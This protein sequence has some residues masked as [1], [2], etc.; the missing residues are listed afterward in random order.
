MKTPWRFLRDLTSRKKL[1]SP[2]A[3]LSL[4]DTRSNRGDPEAEIGPA[5]PASDDEGQAGVDVQITVPADL[6]QTEKPFDQSGKPP[7]PTLSAPAPAPAPVDF[8]ITA[9]SPPT[10]AKTR[11]GTAPSPSPD[12][13]SESAPSQVRRKTEKRAKRIASTIVFEGAFKHK[14]G[15]PA[16]VT[17]QA[18]PE[19]FDEVAGLDDEIRQLRVVLAAKL[20]LQNAQLRKMLERFDVS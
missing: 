12:R 3:Q 4:P 20:T 2:E 18:V 7:V 16:E 5:T 10:E 14:D 17:P 9:A 8:P 19:F 13:T 1:S 6:L 15:Q 11:T